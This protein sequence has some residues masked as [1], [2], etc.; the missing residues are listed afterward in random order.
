M[1]RK[2]PST[3]IRGLDI[4]T[5]FLALATRLESDVQR[6]EP[7]RRK[8]V[9]TA[10]GLLA[11]LLLV[12]LQ[13]PHAAYRNALR[14]LLA[15][16]SGSRRDAIGEWK[17]V[18]AAGFP[19]IN[20]KLDKLAIFGGVVA[21][22]RRGGFKLAEAVE[23]LDG[24]ATGSAY[25]LPHRADSARKSARAV[26]RTPA[27]FPA[28]LSKAY[29]NRIS[30]TP[31]SAGLPTDSGQHSPSD[32]DEKRLRESVAGGGGRAGDAR[33]GVGRSTLDSRGQ[34]VSASRRTTAADSPSQPGR[35]PF[36]RGDKGRAATTK[37]SA[38]SGADRTRPKARARRP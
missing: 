32:G 35:A 24:G 23:L 36:R 16:D 21:E 17:T 29:V 27:L 26:Q 34:A 38:S 2:K 15:E 28:A 30:G 18:R 4:E 37:P 3:S 6:D 22:L 14:F 9:E 12:S 13:Q 7:R 10:I 11:P 20:P 19:V 31:F 1:T 8:A 25:S 33:D 5:A